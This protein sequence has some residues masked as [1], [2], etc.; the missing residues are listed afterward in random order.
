[1]QPPGEYANIF[2]VIQKS[3]RYMQQARSGPGEKSVRNATVSLSRVIVSML[4]LALYSVAVAEIVE[5]ERLGLSAE[6][7]QRI[8]ELVQRSIDAGEI[9]G[10][11]TLVARNGQVAHLHAHGVMDIA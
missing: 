6:R 3:A 10:A 11:V 8:D 9:S 5:P 1:M 7:L 4:A 2:A